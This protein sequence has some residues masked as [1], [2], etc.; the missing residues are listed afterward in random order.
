[1]WQLHGMVCSWSSLIEVGTSVHHPPLFEAL[2]HVL[3]M[4]CSV[5]ASR[6]GRQQLNPRGCRSALC[7]W[8]MTV[9]W[10]CRS[11]SVPHMAYSSLHQF[12]ASH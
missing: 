2:R 4:M 3:C 11:V 12:M 10:L 7:C 5:S 1:M 8:T 9:C 6:R